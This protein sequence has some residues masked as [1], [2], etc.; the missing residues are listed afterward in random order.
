MEAPVLPKRIYRFGVFRLDPD[1]GALV[2][3]GLPVR[4]QGQPLRVLCQLLQHPGEIVT[5]EE[6]RQSL[7]P[8]GTYV[9]FDGSLNAALK[10]LRL[11]LGDDSENPVFIETVPKHGYRFIA[12]VECEQLS[13]A[14]AAAKQPTLL[15]PS[16]W[17]PL[18]RDTD[19]SRRLQP[20]IA[21]EPSIAAGP[22]PSAGTPRQRA[23]QKSVAE[24]PTGSSPVAAVARE[25]KW[26]VVAAF[27]G[28]LIVLAAGYGI[29]A[30]L[31]RS[32]P[33]PF[34]NFTVTQ[35]T[36]DGQ[37]MLAAI[38]PDGRYILSV[39]NENGLESLW[40]RNIP[41]NSDTQILAPAE[42]RYATLAFSP[43]G[44]YIFFREAVAGVAFIF[45]LYRAPVLGGTP[46][47]I[48]RDIDSNIAFSPDGKRMAY[49]RAN[50]PE[51]GKWRLLIAIADGSDE[52][53]LR[54]S[55]SPIIGPVAISW[56]P[57]G[58][59]LAY[60]GV[61]RTTGALT[62][63]VSLFDVASRKARTFVRFSGRS[64]SQLA[65]LPDGSGLLV[66]YR[67]SAEVNRSQIGFLAYPSG[68]F[69]AVTRD[70]D[71]YQSLTLSADGRTFAAVQTKT[72]ENLC[73]L[74]G[75]GGRRAARSLMPVRSFRPTEVFAW[76]D[77]GKL[78]LSRGSAL[79]RV[80]P[81]G[82]HPVTVVSEPA[83]WI[84]DPQE[85]AG[86]RY[87]VFVAFHGGSVGSANVWRADADGSNL[88]E[89][90]AGADEISPACSPDGKWVYYIDVGTSQGMRVP[91]AGGKPEP[92]P[93]LATPNHLFF[94]G[95][96]FSPDGKLLA[97]AAMAED[98]RTHE[99]RR[100]VNLRRLDAGASRSVRVIV[101]NPHIEGAAKFTPDGKSLAY[102]VFE[103]G[104]GNIWVQPLDGS[105]GHTITTFTSEH[106]S[107]FHWSPDGRTLAVVRADTNS[108][109][110]LFRESAVP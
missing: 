27:A 63:E 15:E 53:V 13:G 103:S 104:A 87:I 68:Q 42:T 50:D 65:W 22:T 19:S 66:T 64:V 76:G 72:S 5:R 8:N 10:R 43:D 7:W 109:V 17:Q 23:A 41:T 86:G 28:A 47:E 101:P 84:G 107:E 18:T 92:A 9:E 32:R 60:S 12:P 30:F 90:T 89:L 59:R 73:L 81:E 105:P 14:N 39:K 88:Q 45:N 100:V 91:L 74:L 96:G 61:Y 110:V 31:R 93:G 24:H 34:Q 44:N 46:K 21:A 51:A 37:A 58:K 95:F 2:R 62:E 26:G 16:D 55:E 79:E 97:T 83:S 102:P 38:S 69:R 48:G 108:D 35:T 54:A 56:S 11:A 106:I 99:V 98:P 85:C 77:D 33:I 25:R 82:D 49:I 36:H 94:H 3:K 4:L 29:Y 75:A 6:L 40:L 20:A 67:D 57:D 78:L 70:A 80:S 1:R 71:N 52:R